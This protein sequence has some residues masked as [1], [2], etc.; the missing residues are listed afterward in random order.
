MPGIVEHVLD[1]CDVTSGCLVD[2]T[3]CALCQGN[4]KS[5]MHSDFVTYPDLFLAR[6]HSHHVLYQHN[7]HGTGTTLLLLLNSGSID[8]VH[9]TLR[10][11]SVYLLF[12]YSL[13]NPTYNNGMCHCGKEYLK[14]NKIKI[15]YHYQKKPG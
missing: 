13:E 1:T 9:N 2:S 8:E 12:Q 14:N 5:R 7:H 15:T 11:H 6:I 4:T 10:S 3:G